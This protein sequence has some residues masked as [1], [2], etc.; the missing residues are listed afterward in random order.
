LNAIISIFVVFLQVVA[1][2]GAHSLGG[3][4]LS[5]SGYQGKWSDPQNV[6]FNEL[7]YRNMINPRNK[8]I[9]VVNF[10]E[11]LKENSFGQKKYSETRL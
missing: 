4:H 11:N 2:M 5:N 7:Y 10:R 3:A 9:N 8:W 1:L 6:G